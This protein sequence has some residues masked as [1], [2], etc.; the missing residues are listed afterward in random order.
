MK[1]YL[2]SRISYLLITENKIEMY[3]ILNIKTPFSIIQFKQ[4]T[5]VSPTQQEKNVLIKR[6]A[7]VVF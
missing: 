7:E 5:P 3:L 4:T 6:F 1:N 2:E